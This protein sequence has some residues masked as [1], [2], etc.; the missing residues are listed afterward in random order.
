MAVS[1]AVLFGGW[2]SYQ[3][4]AISDPFEQR[5]AQIDGI[6]QFETE[7]GR[8]QVK[9]TLQLDRPASLKDVYQEISRAAEET[10]SGRSIHI[11]IGSSIG[12]AALEQWWSQALFD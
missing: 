4:Y 10:A 2:F 12:S 7:W 6:Q 1:S 5:L 11:N 8:N 3:T 9:V